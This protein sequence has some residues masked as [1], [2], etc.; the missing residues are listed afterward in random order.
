MKDKATRYIYW[1]KYI[2]FWIVFGAIFEF[3]GSEFNIGVLVA[4]CIALFDKNTFLKCRRYCFSFIK[5]P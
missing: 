2:V 4:I 5:L 3:L 1:I